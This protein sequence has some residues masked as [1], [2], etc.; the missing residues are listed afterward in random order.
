ME[1]LPSNE[2][3]TSP[4]TDE[5]DDSSMLQS[6]SSS[7]SRLPSQVTSPSESAG[8]PWY[9]GEI[10]QTEAEVLLD[11]AQPGRFLVRKAGP[12]RYFLSCVTDNHLLLHLPI[13]QLGRFFYLNAGKFTTLA[14]AVRHH[15]EMVDTA[16]PVHAPFSSSNSSLVAASHSTHM[17]RYITL[18]KCEDLADNDELSTSRG[19]IITQLRILEGNFVLARNENTGQ[20]GYVNTKAVAPV[21]S[22]SLC[23][24]D[25]P[26][27]HPVLTADAL[28]MLTCVGAGAFLVRTS[29]QGADAFALLVNTRNKIEKFLIRGAPEGTEGFVLA[30][31][32]FPS[33]QHIIDRYYRSTPITSSSSLITTYCVHPIAS[34]VRLTHAVLPS[35]SSSSR[36][37]SEDHE[38]NVES[39]AMTT[40]D[41]SPNVTSIETT[42]DYVNHNCTSHTVAAVQALRK[43]RE[44]KAW[45]PCW[46]TL[47]D[48]PNGGCELIISDTEVSAKAR[49]VLDLAYCVMYLL[50][51]S[52]FGRE[53]CV[54]FSQTD[55][56]LP[57]VYLC[58]RPTH[59]LIKWLELLRPRVLGLRT[60][61]VP[62]MIGLQFE[63]PK[64]SFVAVLQLHIDKYRSESLKPDGFYSAYGMICGIKVCSTPVIVA[65][66]GKGAPPSVIFD[67]SFLLPLVPPENGTLQFSVLSHPGGGKKSRPLGVSALFS[68]PDSRSHSDAPESGF[69]F[70]AARYRIRVLGLEQYAPL[71]EYLKEGTADL[72]E[73][74][75][76]ALSIQQRSL[77]CWSIV[78]L[79][80]PTRDDLL[81]L[82]TRLMRRVLASSTGDN[83]M[84][85]DSLTTTLLTQALRIAGRSRLED[86][87]D[88]LGVS[89]VKVFQQA[90]IDHVVEILDKLVTPDSLLNDLLVSVAKVACERFPDEPHLVR[91]V[92]SNVYILRFAN[93]LLIALLNGNPLNQQLAKGVQ[94]AANVAAAAT[95]RLEDVTVG[96][97][98]LRALFERLRDA[99]TEV[100]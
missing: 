86:A 59:V 90:D 66:P 3:V 67:C 33:L 62:V 64:Q 80:L 100:T 85:Q 37:P 76:D 4:C 69:T 17:R 48:D 52:V 55:I 96:S 39:T 25:L 93:P 22:E 88:S 29:S 87:L 83:V 81:G 11:V 74:A 1:M 40:S 84:R 7:S 79:L 68:L 63:P 21:L 36:H 9:H 26:Y 5:H 27:F 19:D 14:E 45:K 70:R 97:Q 43:S 82:I 10:S 6:T 94:A 98:C 71:M 23:V 20:T 73:W 56:D 46:L 38:S 42:S 77:L 65:S 95:P 34:D 32:R 58:F 28:K 72:L 2:I 99:Q 15:C 8:R 44:E 13:H 92:L 54:F 18:S 91:R 78:S 51:D 75:S 41:W 61:A 89:G 35:Q 57:G 24:Q 47:C 53:G 50:D 16:E 60:G 49:L 31:R 12:T 30:G